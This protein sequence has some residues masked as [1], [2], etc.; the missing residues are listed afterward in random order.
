MEKQCM[1]VRAGT[2]AEGTTGLTYASGISAGTAGTRA[3]CLELATLPPGA[4][5]RAHLHAGHESAAYILEGQLELWFGERL[6][7]K[8]VAGAGEFV[9]IPDDVP[10][11]AANPSSTDQAVAVLARTDP[12]EQE[13]A[14]PL[15][16]LDSLPHLDAFNSR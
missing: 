4:R 12:G 7:H 2:A 11:V 10:H 8:L 13:S 14:V 3:L 6:E 9:Y 5:G 16:A 1:L 15:P